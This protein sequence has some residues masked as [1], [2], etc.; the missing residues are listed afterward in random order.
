MTEFFDDLSIVD[1]Y[2]SDSVYW[3]KFVDKNLDLSPSRGGELIAKTMKLVTTNRPASGRALMLRFKEEEDLRKE[4][5][6][7]AE[8]EQI[9]RGRLHLA[10]LFSAC[11][12]E[13]QLLELLFDR[14]IPLMSY[15][16]AVGKYNNSQ[17]LLFGSTDDVSIRS[18]LTIKGKGAAAKSVEISMSEFTRNICNCTSTPFSFRQ[19]EISEFDL[20]DRMVARKTEID[21]VVEECTQFHSRLVARIGL[22]RKVCLN[23]RTF[24]EVGEIQRA[25]LATLNHIYEVAQSKH[26][27]LQECGVTPWPNDPSYIIDAKL[28]ALVEIQADP[29]ATA[30]APPLP[31]P[32][33]EVNICVL[34]K[35]VLRVGTK[36]SGT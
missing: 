11:R 33:R 20:R 19:V 21:E 13:Q 1:P 16:A 25:A 9:I 4:I 28:K 3:K 22:F 34:G 36:I 30:T 31:T 15:R 10:S 14:T 32:L 35:S 23:G 7:Y 24:N 6:Q 12:S 27:C 2:E 5:E 8:G 18:G 17:S 26:L 29:S